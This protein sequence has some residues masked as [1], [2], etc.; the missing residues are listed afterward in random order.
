MIVEMRIRPKP[1]CTSHLNMIWICV[2]RVL[3][4]VYCS[5]FE[6]ELVSLQGSW[7]FMEFKCT[8]SKSNQVPAKFLGFP[9]TFSI[10]CTSYF[11]FL[12]QVGGGTTPGVFYTW[13]WKFISKL[14]SRMYS[15]QIIFLIPKPES[16]V[17]L[18]GKIP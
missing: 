2:F 16:E 10:Q 1:K 4:L 12:G 5:D 7:E 14:M 8:S 9:R 15:G 13:Q 18:G 11:C 6:F 3:R 17:I